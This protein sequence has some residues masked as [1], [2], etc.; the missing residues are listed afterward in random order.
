MRD[1]AGTG[2][3][4]NAIEDMRGAGDGRGIVGQSRPLRGRSPGQI[5]RPIAHIFAS[6]PTRKKHCRARARDSAT[7]QKC[8]SV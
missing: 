6:C 1:I 2:T 5:P 7:L 3:E 4:S 8:A